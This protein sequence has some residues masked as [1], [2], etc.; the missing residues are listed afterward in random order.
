MNDFLFAVFLLALLA[1]VTLLPTL[2]LFYIFGWL[3]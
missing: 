3:A 2:G 1:W